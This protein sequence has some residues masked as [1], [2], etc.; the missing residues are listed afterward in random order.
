MKNLFSKSAISV[1][2]LAF[3]ALCVAIPANA[4]N[5][6]KSVKIGAGNTSSGESSVNGSIS[7]GAGAKVTGD[8]STVNGRIRIDDDAEVEDVSTVNGG[9]RVGTGSKTEDLSTVNG[10]ITIAQNVTIDGEIEAVNGEIEL[11]KDSEVRRNVS[12]VNGEI[13]LRA[14]K[15]GGDVSTVTGDIELSDGAEVMGDIVVEEPKGW[16]WSNKKQRTP[17]VVIGPGS[18]VHGEI[19]LEREVE[20]YISDTAQVGRVTGEMSLDDAVRFSGKKP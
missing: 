17:R 4:H 11:D 20:L 19:R 3:L 6:N 8:L 13:E 12:N 18:T 16:G 14:S 2:L 7:V 5:A 1:S 15:V 10:A 9:L